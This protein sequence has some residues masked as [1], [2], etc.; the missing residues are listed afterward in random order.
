MKKV[1]SIVLIAMLVIGMAPAALASLTGTVQDTDES[2]NP[3]GPVYGYS[4]SITTGYPAVN[5]LTAGDIDLG[6]EADPTTNEF[7]YALGSAG[8]YE[9]TSPALSRNTYFIDN[10]ANNGSKWAFVYDGYTRQTIKDDKIAVELRVTNGQRVV[11]EVEIEYLESITDPDGV[12]WTFTKNEQPAFIRITFEDL[13]VSTSE[14]DYKFMVYLTEDKKRQTDTEVTFEGTFANNETTVDEGDV[15][16]YLGDDVPVV[17]S[18][19]YLKDIDIE[20]DDGITVHTKFFNNKKYYANGEAKVREEDDEILERYPEIDYVYNID[21]VGLNNSYTSVSLNIED[22]LYVYNSNME[23]IGTTAD[24]LPYSTKYYVSSVELDVEDADVEEPA[25]EPDP[26]DEFD[27][28]A[29]M[30]GDDAP[31]NYNDNPGTGC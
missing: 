24:R 10:T 3:V 6:E 11:E 9:A 27:P 30:G 29:N 8:W 28:G 22:T 19:A 16:V 23:Q 31:S 1:L 4:K 20:L 14:V 21:S 13:F 12:K 15:Y 26:G 17:E 18:L 5:F 2:G 25:A 7:D